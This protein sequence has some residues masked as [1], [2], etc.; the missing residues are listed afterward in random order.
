MIAPEA[1]RPRAI[2]LVGMRG[3][4]KSTVGPALAHA[5]DVPFVEMDD[6]IADAAG[7]RQ[8]QIFE[9]HGAEFYRRIE[10]EVLRE[11]LATGEPMVL[12]TPG[13]VVEEPANWELLL[14]G[15]R[16]VWLKARV[17]DHWNRVVGQGDDRPMRDRPDA[18]ETLRSML[19]T[20][21]RRYRDA[22]VV[23]DTHDRTPQAIVESLTR[24]LRA[25]P[26][27]KGDATA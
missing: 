14:E 6:R 26:D 22:H 3:A 12:A 15:A 24:R 23:E 25:S 1:E 21:E 20:R 4:G 19:R 13:G 16:V 11:L 9:L 8:D 5:L 10:R 7:L 17:D 18:R 2:A 27:T